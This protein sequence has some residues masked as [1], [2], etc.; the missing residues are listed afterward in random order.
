MKLSSSCLI[1]RVL[2]AQTTLFSFCF[3][4]QSEHN[5]SPFL[6]KTEYGSQKNTNTVYCR[7]SCSERTLP[8][9][10]KSQTFHHPY[11]LTFVW[12]PPH[13]PANHDM[14]FGVSFSV[15]WTAEVFLGEI[16]AMPPSG[17]SE[18]SSADPSQ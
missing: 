8:T 18:S 5:T 16:E 3:R 17:Q 14:Y 9:D 7:C 6:S 1:Y 10:I 4:E 2:R 15:P 11:P 12:Q 13:N